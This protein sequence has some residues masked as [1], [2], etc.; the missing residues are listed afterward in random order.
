ME[1]P[2]A[3]ERTAYDVTFSY[4]KDSIWV[5]AHQMLINGKA[6]DITREDFLKVASKVGIKKADAIRSILAIRMSS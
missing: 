5:S 6:D 1:R 3:N 4:K 2:E